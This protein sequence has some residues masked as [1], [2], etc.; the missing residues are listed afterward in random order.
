[1][2]FK[3][4][5]SPSSP[6]YTGL[7]PNFSALGSASAAF[8]HLIFCHFPLVL[9]DLIMPNYFLCPEKARLFDIP[10]SMLILLSDSERQWLSKWVFGPA[11]AV[12]G[13]L[14]KIC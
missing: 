9:S 10:A 11:V 13:N 1:M 4:V 12:P 5:N 6:K 14:L 3:A 8:S 2:F 7:T